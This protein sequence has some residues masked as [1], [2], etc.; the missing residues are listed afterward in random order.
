MEAIVD[1]TALNQVDGKK[2]RRF[3]LLKKYL[4]N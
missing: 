3:E 4:I 2:L 1:G